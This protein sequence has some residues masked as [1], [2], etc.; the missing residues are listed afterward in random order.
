MVLPGNTL[1]ILNVKQPDDLGQYM[2]VASN[3]Y[4]SDNKTAMGN[5]F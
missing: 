5:I 1:L 3:Q 2:C 4:G